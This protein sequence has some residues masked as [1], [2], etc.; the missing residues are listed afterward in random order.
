[1]RTT[2]VLLAFAMLLWGGS[3]A[4]ST[5][6]LPHAGLFVFDVSPV[7]DVPAPASR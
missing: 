3:I 4:G 5:D 7:L 2:T 6:M 1:M